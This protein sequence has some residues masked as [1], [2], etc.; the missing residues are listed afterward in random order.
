MLHLNLRY[1]ATLVIAAATLAACDAEPIAPHTQTLVRTSAVTTTASANTISRDDATV[2]FS[3]VVFAACANGGQGE[4]LQVNGN[5]QYK[6][7]WITT[8]Q[9]QRQHYVLVASFTGSGIG[10]DS[11]EEYDVVTRE[12]SQGNTAYGT[13]GIPDSGE[14]LQRIALRLTSR[15]TGATFDVVL[16]GRFVQTPTGEFVLDG[17]EAR[18]RCD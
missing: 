18:T 11:G 5:L 15:E 12:I 13:D 16:V 9:G 17:W 7:H 10:W 8:T 1:A 6:G 14:E 2:P 4:V 3:F